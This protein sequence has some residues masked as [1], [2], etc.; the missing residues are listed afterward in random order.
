M[1]ELRRWPWPHNAV[2][3]QNQRSVD[4]GM[5]ADYAGPNA[6]K[7]FL[8]NPAAPAYNFRHVIPIVA[9]ERFLRQ[10]WWQSEFHKYGLAGFKLTNDLTGQSGRV[11]AAILDHVAYHATIGDLLQA[12]YPADDDALKLFMEKADAALSARGHVILANYLTGL[13]METIMPEVEDRRLDFESKTWARTYDQEIGG[14]ATKTL[15]DFRAMDLVVQNLASTP[16]ADRPHVKLDNLNTSLERLLQSDLL[17]LHRKQAEMLSPTV[18]SRKLDSFLTSLGRVAYH[19]VQYAQT[20]LGI[21]F[22]QPPGRRDPVRIHVLMLRDY[23]KRV[24][25]NLRQVHA[26][27]AGW[28]P[29]THRDTLRQPL[30]LRDALRVFRYLT[31]QDPLL[32]DVPDPIDGGS[33]RLAVLNSVMR[34]ETLLLAVRDM[35]GHLQSDLAHLDTLLR[36][37]SPESLDDPAPATSSVSSAELKALSRARCKIGRIRALRRAA[38]R[39]LKA[40]GRNRS[41]GG[42]GSG[43]GADDE[44]LMRMVRTWIN[45]L[46]AR[47]DLAPELRDAQSA[48]MIAELFFSLRAQRAG[49]N[50]TAAGG[51]AEGKLWDRVQELMRRDPAVRD[52]LREEFKSEELAALGI[53]L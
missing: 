8:L 20:V 46:S 29:V 28:W 14:L 17:D 15:N 41:G 35:V 48:V 7:T 4:T 16:L 42:A 36:L 3:L 31:E 51:A 6:Y 33:P 19:A 40:I 30:S 43:G 27:I 44:R 26:A 22:I 39:E 21:Y 1:I 9:Y 24:R 34:L 50:P 10:S 38:L 49:G 45:V 25:N 53:E 13:T 32:S 12:A 5:Y 11:P 47:R 23:L 52:R 18:P 2:Q 37:S